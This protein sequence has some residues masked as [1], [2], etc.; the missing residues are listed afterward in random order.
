MC[1][2]PL[3]WHLSR[4]HPPSPTHRTPA[5]ERHGSSLSCHLAQVSAGTKHNCTRGSNQRDVTSCTS[6]QTYPLRER[7]VKKGRAVWRREHPWR[8]A[9]TSWAKMP[10]PQPTRVSFIL[11][12]RTLRLPPPWAETLLNDP[13]LCFL[14]GWM[15]LQPPGPTDDDNDED[16][17]GNTWRYLQQTLS[18][19]HFS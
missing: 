9:A 19:R 14:P 3:L 10:G 4:S 1:D 6:G 5:T 7:P 2:P 15:G 13:P 11:H 12:L 18:G 8:D 16:G 17:D